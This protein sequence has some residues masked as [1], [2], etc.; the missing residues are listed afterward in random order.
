VE[1]KGI[2]AE[3]VEGAMKGRLT[4]VSAFT[5]LSG[6]L[7]L[8]NGSLQFSQWKDQLTRIIK[9][10][11]EAFPLLDIIEEGNY[12]SYIFEFVRLGGNKSIGK[13]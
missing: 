2:N 11:L 13:C 7:D 8:V 12:N 1:S 5:A 10:P 4:N 3:L 6:H 9:L